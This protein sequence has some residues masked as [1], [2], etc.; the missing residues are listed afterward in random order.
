[1]GSDFLISQQ[2]A[3]VDGICVLVDDAA[4]GVKQPDTGSLGENGFTLCVALC[5]ILYDQG[6]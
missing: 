3:S 6:G 2:S 4:R 1:M 5:V